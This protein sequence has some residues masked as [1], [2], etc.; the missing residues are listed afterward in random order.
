MPLTDAINTLANQIE[1]VSFNDASVEEVAKFQSLFLQL[2][3]ACNASRT[4]NTNAVTALRNARN[5]ILSR[6]N[7]EDFSD[8]NNV[9]TR[10][11][12]IQLLGNINSAIDNSTLLS[13]VVTL[14]D[15]DNINIDASLSNNFYIAFDSGRASRTLNAPTNPLGDGQ[16]INFRVKTSASNQILTLYTNARGFRFSDSASENLFVISTAPDKTDYFT[17]RY[18]LADDKWDVQALIKGF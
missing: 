3:E 14:V 9:S 8:L 13:F 18:N 2:I 5:I 17:A 7:S 10:R 1:K 16:V 4:A 12:L 11:N 15:A 6:L